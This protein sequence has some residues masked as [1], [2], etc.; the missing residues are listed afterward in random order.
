VEVTVVTV[1]HFKW[2]YKQSMNSTSPHSAVANELYEMLSP[3]VQA[4]LV[5]A[6]RSMTVPEGTTLIRQ[7]VPPENLVIIN[8][9]KVAVSLN[10]M[11]GAASVD[12]SEP[13]K[14]FGMRALVSGELPEINVTCVESCSITVVPRDSFLSLLQNNPEIYFGVAKVLSSDLK[15]ADRILRKNSRRF[16]CGPRSRTVKP[17]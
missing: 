4:E 10:C 3:G 15:I 6:E 12:Y 14:V 2:E 1:L 7:G 5:K 8:S 9:G 16:F 13:G 17:D 11:R